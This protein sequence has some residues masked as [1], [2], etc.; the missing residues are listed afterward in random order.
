MTYLRYI[1]DKVL[2]LQAATGMYNLMGSSVPTPTK[3]LDKSFF[4]KAGA[5]EKRQHKLRK[6][7]HSQHPRQWGDQRLVEAIRRH[8][9]HGHAEALQ[10]MGGRV[11]ILPVA[12]S[13]PALWFVF[14]AAFRDGAGDPKARGRVLVETPTYGPFFEIP[15]YLG[16]PVDW[17]PRRGGC[18]EIDPADVKR[19]VTR[20]TR[21]VVLSNLHNP[22]GHGL[23]P[24]ALLAIARA[25]RESNPDVKIL[26]DETFGDFCGVP[27]TPAAVLDPCFVSVSGLTKVYGLGNLRCGWILATGD[28]FEAITEA[29]LQVQNIGSA[30]TEAMATVAL[31]DR[32]FMG[33]S[34]KRL[35]RQRQMVAHKLA[36]LE[37]RV[38]LTFP[39]HGCICFP[40]VLGVPA[41]ELCADLE[42]VEHVAVVP[43]R[44]FRAADHVR[45][46]FGGF[47]KDSHLEAA[48]DA[49][50]EGVTRIIDQG[51]RKRSPA[52]R[53]RKA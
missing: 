24:S 7:L 1:K 50:C 44:F 34:R 16:L 3:L 42:M 51:A 25:A 39:P 17:L 28:F 5:H 32:R 19:L 14:Q 49:L 18:F 4:A 47:L 29:W 35:A 22:S 48:L 10:G 21:L 31:E 52:I 46:G 45:I 26:V 33:W 12:G 23:S 40:K 27:Y 6:I 13:S 43:G 36:A 9:Q 37:D 20:Q 8:Y 30:V 53:R 2:E 11:D 41:D 38:E 15:Q